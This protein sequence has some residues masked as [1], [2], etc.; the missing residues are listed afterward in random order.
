M[1]LLERYLAAVRILLPRK[2]REDIIAELREAL[3]E[4][5]DE[6]AAELGHALTQE[7]DES[8]LREFGHPMVIAARY[9][10]QQYLI[11]PDLYP[12]YVFVVKMVLGWVLAAAVA[13]GLFALIGSLIG[14]SGMPAA[15]GGWALTIAW[16]GA[17]ICWAI[18]TLIFAILQRT[19]PRPGISAAWRVRDLPQ[20]RQ[21][22]ESRT[23]V[24][25]N[26][27]GIAASV[28]FILWWTH[29]IGL[30]SSIQVAPGQSLEV[31]L[32]PVWLG[33]Y[34]PLL[35]LAVMNLVVHGLRLLRDGKLRLGTLLDLAVQLGSLV[36]IGVALRAGHWITFAGTGI[37]KRDLAQ[38]EHWA[39]VGLAVALTVVV[40]VAVFRAAHNLW[41]LPR[42]TACM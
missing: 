27:V 9:G 4:R 31:G 1:D 33:L 42:A 14:L 7:E 36:V 18:V 26:I 40:C 28:L 13:V 23:R 6:R 25:E 39:N 30:P 20:V 2:Q 21:A 35:G 37:P 16:D 11:G 15:A 29:L 12:V 34:W 10:G 19:S 22:V 3:T 8:L 24:F 38:L 32:D 41:K 5:R 17:F